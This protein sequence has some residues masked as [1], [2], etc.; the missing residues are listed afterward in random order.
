LQSRPGEGS[1]FR[2]YFPVTAHSRVARPATGRGASL[3]GSGTVLVIDDESVVR[4][5]AKTVLERKGYRTM[6][7]ENGESGVEIF[8]VNHRYLDL[9]LLDF[10]M[11]VMNGEEALDRMRVVSTKVPVILSSGFSQATAAERFQGKELAGFLEKP[12]NASQLVEAVAAA[13]STKNK[14]QIM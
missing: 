10:T 12:Y 8:R 13:I 6:L 3:P 11:P 4:T 2:L 7:A 14:T 1:T 5:F 9:V